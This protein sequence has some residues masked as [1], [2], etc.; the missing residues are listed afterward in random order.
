MCVSVLSCWYL[1]AILSVSSHQFGKNREWILLTKFINHI[2]NILDYRSQV[3]LF[4]RILTPTVSSTRMLLPLEHMMQ[5]ELN[6]LSTLIPIWHH[7]PLFEIKFD[8]R[9]ELKTSKFGRNKKGEES[10]TNCHLDSVVHG[11]TVCKLLSPTQNTMY[12]KITFPLAS[13]M[14]L[15]HTV[16]SCKE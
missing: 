12:T 6:N 3:D 11:Y 10:S 7:P 8:C 1:V 14:F 13:I 4:I 2:D 5:K 15:V 9:I 16:T